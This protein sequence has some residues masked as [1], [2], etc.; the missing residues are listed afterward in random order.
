MRKGTGVFCAILALTMVLA[1]CNFPGSAVGA[2]GRTATSAAITLQARATEA[3]QATEPP[4]I[5]LP[6]PTSPPTVITPAASDTSTVTPTLRPTATATPIPCN[7]AEFVKDVNY[8]DNTEVEIGT[9]ITKTWQLKN[10]GTCTWTTDYD[11]VFGSGDRMDAPATQQLSADPVKPGE[12]VSVSVELTVP[13]EPDTYRADFKLRSGDGKV[14]G[15]GVSGASSF[16][17]QIKAVQVALP[18]LRIKSLS[19]QPATPTQGE[20]VDVTVVIR[21]RG[22]GDAGEF[23][24]GWWPDAQGDAACTWLVA[25]LDAGAEVTKTCTYAGYSE[26]HASITTVARADVGG[27]IKESD[28]ENNS[29]SLKIEVLAP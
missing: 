6:P 9:T 7:R 27:A 19:L 26:S 3:A 2:E 1:A 21:N 12:T 17:V 24:V 18:D 4:A 8:P 25:E 14:F 11:L 28:E 23:S 20:E 13:D 15:V 22:E 29:A 16:W 10:V 5:T